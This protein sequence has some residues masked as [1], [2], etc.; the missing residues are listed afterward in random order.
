MGLIRSRVDSGGEKMAGNPIDHVFRQVNAGWNP[1]L[2]FGFSSGAMT[3]VPK[4]QAGNS[5]PRT[6]NRLGIWGGCVRDYDVG[7]NQQ[8]C[9][10]CAAL[11]DIDAK[12]GHNGGVKN[13]SDEVA[14][15][16]PEAYV[17]TS[18][19]GSGA[20]AFLVLEN[21]IECSAKRSAQRIAARIAA[22]FVQRLERAGIKA[23]VVAR[24]Q[25]WIAGGRQVDVTLGTTVSCDVVAVPDQPTPSPAPLHS[26]PVIISGVGKR[27]CE[28]LTTLADAGLIQRDNRAAAQYHLHI[29]TVQDALRP[30]GWLRG[31]PLYSVTSAGTRPEQPNSVLSLG[32]GVLSLWTFTGGGLECF[33]LPLS[34]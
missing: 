12:N 1:I 22:P 23:D 3:W 21:P 13:V 24:N 28:V 19:G 16:L 2:C 7:F 31:S 5:P 11:L 34:L 17:R 30:I 29:K 18:S 33:R 15:A 25:L 32:D 20:H 14:A 6:F 10:L 8:P 27:C 26:E 4:S 9:L